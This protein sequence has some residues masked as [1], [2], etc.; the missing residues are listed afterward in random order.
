MRLLGGDFA[1]RLSDKELLEAAAGFV[2]LALPPRLLY[3]WSNDETSNEILRQAFDSFKPG[4]VAI[5]WIRHHWVTAVCTGTKEWVVLDSA[6]SEPVRRT[7]NQVARI[8][9]WSSPRTPNVRQ[10]QAGSNE[11]GIFAL[12]FAFLAARGQLSEFAGTNDPDTRERLDLSWCRPLLLA[13]RFDEFFA[14]VTAYVTSSHAKDTRCRQNTATAGQTATSN[15]T[16]R[17]NNPYATV[18]GL[19]SCLQ[20]DTRR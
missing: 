1:D 8:A 9:G 20:E 4:H 3:D 17:V 10:Q 16:V 19:T 12:V 15:T 11:C 6:R 13:G 2:S 5:L 7:L 18:F 14:R